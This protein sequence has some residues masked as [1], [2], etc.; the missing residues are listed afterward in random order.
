MRLV[1]APRR[2]HHV[3]M[4]TSIKPSWFASVMGTGIVANAA[5]LLPFHSPSLT[6]VAVLFWVVAAG[7]LIVLLTAG[8]LQLA[9]HPTL[10]RS[11]HHSLQVAPF[12]GAFSMGILTVGSGALLA[13]SHLIGTSAAVWIDSVLWTAGTATGLACAVGIPYMLFTEHRPALSDAYGSWLMPVVPPMVSAAAGAG[14]IAHLAPGQARLDLLYGCYA[15]FGISLV[16]ALIVIAILWARLA[17]HGVGESRMV[18]TLWIVLGPLGQSITAVSLLAKAA[19]SAAAP[20]GIAH[21][22]RDFAVVYGLPIWG[23][24]VAWLAL[25]IAITIKSAREGLPFAP[26]WWSFT[27]PLGTVVTGTS[28]LSA[29]SHVDV[30]RYTAAGLFVALLCAWLTVTSRTLLL[31]FRQAPRPG[32]AAAPSHRMNR[33]GRDQAGSSTKTGISRSVFCWYCA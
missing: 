12:Y 14:L 18:P 22:F 7:L 31:W 4:V 32:R 15:M 10:F 13:G 2:V 23:F 3:P 16:M 20:A 19:P 25:V 9:R 1:R 27:F 33:R 17:L 5:M 26:T 6:A 28:L 24:A 29:S 8:A 21:A 11:H 30:L